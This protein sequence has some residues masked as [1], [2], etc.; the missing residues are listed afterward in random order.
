[1]AFQLK[2]YQQAALERLR[3]YLLEMKKYQTDKTAGV[4]FM[5]LRTDAADG[6]D[7]NYH[8]IPELGHSPFVCVKI[9]T[10]GGKTLIAAHA[11]GAIF[12]DYLGQRNDKGL[13][14][15]FVPSDA[16]KGQT[17]INLRDRNHPYRE[18][19]DRRFGNAVKIFDLA[20][21]KAVK[22]DDLANNLCV[23]ISTLSAFRR[24]NRE[25]LKVY[26]DNGAL[27]PHFEEVNGV[28]FDFLEKDSQGEIIYSLANVIKLCHP[29]V[30][31][32]EGHNAQT[33]LSF[34]MLKTLNPSFI[35]EFTATPRSQSNVLVN[36][37]A[38]ELKAEKMI[39]M[40]IY[41]A[42]KTPWQETICD[43][44]AKLAEL[45]KIAKKESGGHIRPIMLL[46]AEQEKESKT[47]IFVDQIYKFLTE[48]RKI[49]AEQIAIQTGS[50]KDLPEMK[51]LLGKDCPIRYII[52]V[53]AL[54]EGWDCPFA[55]VLVSVS[56][57]GARLS[58]EQ[59]IGRIMRLPGAE[60]K[61]NPALNAA[62]VFAATNNFSQTSEMVI[63][64]LQENGYEDIVANENVVAAAKS[65]FKKIIKDD[66]A[67]IPFINIKDGDKSRK[68]D[69]AADLIGNAPIFGDEDAAIDFAINENRQ[70]VK[71]DIDRHGELVRDAA[72]ERGIIYRY[73]NFAKNDLIFW[74]GQ[75]I[76]RGFIGMTEMGDYLN[77]V[78]DK[79]SKKRD[80]NDLV[81]HSYD[82]MDAIDKKIDEIVDKNTKQ[83][84]EL[85]ERK[86]MLI[87]AGQNYIFGDY[88]NYNKI[89]PDNFAKHLYE[90]A[91]AMNGE[92]AELAR[93]LDGLES[94]RW[95]ARNPEIGGFYIQGWRKN[96]F[97]PDFAAKTK[98]GNYFII[99]Y[100]GEHLA[101][102]DDSEYKK[103]IGEIWAKLSG[104]N[105]YFEFVE[106]NNIADAIARIA[107]F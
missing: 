106:K 79:L 104:A 56:H 20:E 46:Q 27:L 25:W 11:L 73:K 15:W 100:K 77:L 75:K 88:V 80:V 74:L 63:K 23:V 6:F 31:V 54:R 9:P 53:N 89:L 44:I 70:I 96:K 34:E 51:I 36:V 41:L 86:K 55:Y 19:L 49:P 12:A 83:K 91:G 61:T 24:T 16:I 18:T 62:Y 5:T 28:D 35:L 42:N 97:Y 103:Q 3:D 38:K 78:V 84:F 26:Q 102:G 76:Q 57:L 21:A 17:L 52:T 99:E 60:E 81:R 95:W 39:K 22:P 10:G 58:V 37:S 48:E 69:Y 98:K 2:K 94:L 50:K 13:A 101:G 87:G 64:G 33:N 47:K 65:E 72:G 90:N 66:N 105:Y 4:A 92:E 93:R 8:W 85:L 30:I 59:T 7:K 43:G 82:L 71:I 68:I 32:D 1:M 107:G 14:M 29:P 67:Q 40:P 45:E